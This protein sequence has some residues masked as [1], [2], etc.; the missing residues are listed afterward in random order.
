MEADRVLVQLGRLARQV[1][2]PIIRSRQTWQRWAKHGVR[3]GMRK[4]KLPT[5]KIDGVEHTTVA[6]IKA[7]FDEHCELPKVSNRGGSR[8][9]EE[10]NA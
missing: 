10:P 3:I 7:F 5:V 4:Y 6:D 1:G 8:A 9:Q 2:L